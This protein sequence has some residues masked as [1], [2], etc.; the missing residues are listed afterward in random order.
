MR[1]NEQVKFSKAWSDEAREAS[2]ESRRE[3]SD[4]TRHELA[5]RPGR[6]DAKLLRDQEHPTV[7]GYELDR[8]TLK[9]I[10]RTIDLNRPGDHGAD[11]LGGGK[12]RMVPSG[13]VVDFEERNK[14]LAGRGK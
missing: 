3:H 8:E 4:R 14:R 7:L 6:P 1:V 10:S 2:A 9:P 12:F 5:Q 11:P 13:D